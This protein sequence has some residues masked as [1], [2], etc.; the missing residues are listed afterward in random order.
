GSGN[1]PGTPW[2]WVVWIRTR[3]VFSR[4]GNDRAA[5]SPPGFRSASNNTSLGRVPASARRSK[6]K[7]SRSG[8]GC[9]AFAGPSARRGGRLRTAGA[10]ARRASR[11]RGEQMAVLA[12]IEHVV[13]QAQGDAQVG[14]VVAVDDRAAA[15]AP[16][17]ERY[18]DARPQRME[19][20]IVHG[21]P[22]SL[23]PNVR[24]NPLR[25]IAPSGETAISITVQGVS[26]FMASG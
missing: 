1:G 14:E 18:A 25:R 17:Q 7:R 19:Y 20:R 8:A 24:G 26:C 4:A 10:R 9:R 13:V 3:C 23:A 16:R 15:R 22:L 6:T 21:V 2:R 5:K 11:A 12:E